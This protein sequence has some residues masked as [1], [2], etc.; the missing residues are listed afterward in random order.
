MARHA[1]LI[2]DPNDIEYILSLKEEDFTM[3]TIMELFGK[4]GDKRRFNPYDEFIIP[5]GRYGHGDYINKKDCYTTVGLYIFNKVFIE[6]DFLPI[7]RYIN[8][9]INKKSFGK[10]TSE[11]G[12][13]LLEQDITR[14]QMDHFTEQTQR[15]MP[16]VNILSPGFSEKMLTCDEQ[17]RKEINKIVEDPEIKKRLENS[18]EY[19]A[20]EIEDKVLN[21]MKEYLKDDESM[22]IYNSGA[23]GSFGNNFKN[24]FCMKGAIKDPDPNKGYNIVL[25]SYMGGISKEDYV[26]M[27]NSLAAG[28]YG[29]AKL[30]ANGGY[31]E[32]IMTNAYQHLTLDEKGSD[33]G[34]DKYITVTLTNDNIKLYM[35]CYVIN[36]DGTLT[37]ITRKN[38]KDFI[39]KTVNMRFACMCK[40]KTGF[41]NACAGNLFYR[42]GFKNIGLAT[43]IVASTIKTKTMKGFHNSTVTFN[44]MNPMEAFGIE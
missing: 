3:T 6:R 34:T 5:K 33:C 44:E 35:Y 38:K 12:L 41:C 25:S 1:T 20:N 23:R 39:G 22:D 32:K 19:A 40:S 7:F 43:N 2:S 15:F 36:D 30:T 14:E 4:F 10:I 29:R 24:L 18:D 26:A 28:P 11:L 21:K 42:L 31:K 9:N 37:E 16:F 27:A 13:C 8:Y 17:C